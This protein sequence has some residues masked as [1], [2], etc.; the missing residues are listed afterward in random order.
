MQIQN[1]ELLLT[2]RNYNAVERKTRQEL[3]NSKRESE[4]ESRVNHEKPNMT[5]TNGR[6]RK[7]HQDDAGEVALG[8]FD[9][10]LKGF[11]EVN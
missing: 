6:H 11:S 7:H 9:R 5:I 10:Q 8:T 1:R 4:I 2:K 3:Q